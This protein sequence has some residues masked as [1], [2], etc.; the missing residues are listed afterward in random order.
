AGHPQH[1]S[2]DEDEMTDSTSQQTS[3]GTTGAGDQEPPYRYTAELA[4]QIE[5]AWQDRWEREGT[6]HSANPAGPWAEPDDPRL[7]RGHVMVMDMFPYPSG[8]GLHVG[9]PLGFIA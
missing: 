9:H 8:A 6:F 4:N 3:H 7:T 5:A 2:H 1:A